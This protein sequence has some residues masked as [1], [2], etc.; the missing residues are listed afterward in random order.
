MIEMSRSTVN[1][2]RFALRMRRNARATLRCTYS[3][4]FAIDSLRSPITGTQ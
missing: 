2:P 1:R 4:M 3:Q